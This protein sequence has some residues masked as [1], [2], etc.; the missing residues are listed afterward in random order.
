MH[1]ANDPQLSINDARKLY[2]TLR[3]AG[4]HNA[5]LFECNNKTM[6]HLNILDTDTD[7]EKS[8]KID[9]I[10]AIYKRHGLPYNKKL[11]RDSQEVHSIIDPEE[12]QP[13]VDLVK[14]RINQSTWKARCLRNTIDLVTFGSIGLYIA[15]R[16]GYTKTVFDALLKR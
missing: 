6:A 4:N 8:K 15:H 9:A 2:C 14:N 12:F 3:E 7:E 13:S 1:H 5:Y 16:Y 11:L 10:Q